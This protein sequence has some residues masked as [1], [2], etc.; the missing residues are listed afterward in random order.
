MRK[1]QFVL[2]MREIGYTDYAIGIVLS[3]IERQR[4][5]GKRIQYEQYLPD[6]YHKRR[7]G[8]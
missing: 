3:E 6:W 7:S 1:W 2:T 8:E 4:K 5:L